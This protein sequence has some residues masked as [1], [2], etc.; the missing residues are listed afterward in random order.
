[1]CED[2]VLRQRRIGSLAQLAERL[3]EIARRC[4]V[5][6]IV[7]DRPTIPVTTHRC[8]ATSS[9]APGDSRRRE[10]ASA[11]G[12]AAK[13]G[14]G[15]IRGRVLDRARLRVVCRRLGQFARSRR[16]RPGRARIAADDVR[17]RRA[18]A[19]KGVRTVV[20]FFPSRT[21][22]RNGVPGHGTSPLCAFSFLRQDGR[23]ARSAT[24]WC[25]SPA[26]ARPCVRFATAPEVDE[27]SGGPAG[28]TLRRGRLPVRGAICGDG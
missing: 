2:P 10:Y 23:C 28:D 17:R 1:M 12:R 9:P 3:Q 25:R 26:D 6:A 8:R 19:R 24:R 27:W 4:P 20:G 22:A 14:A 5:Q 15:L 7:C 11:P 13:V 18:E 21:A 16:S